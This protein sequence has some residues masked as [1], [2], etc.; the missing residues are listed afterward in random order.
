MFKIKNGTIH[1]SRGDG[2]TIK[3]KIPIVDAKDYIKYQ[4]VSNNI[5]WYNSKSKILYDSN[6]EETEV[7]LNTLS[8]VLY[9]FQVD[10]KVTFNIYEKKGYDKDPLM[11]KEVIVSEITDCV[12]IP[13]SK[14]NTTF[15]EQINKPTIFWYD[16]TLNE[17][18]T[19]VG[20]NE[21]GEKE[22]IEYPA[23]GDG[24]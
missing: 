24:E 12:D 3:L 8:M 9:E 17:K 16:I 21:D 19:I 13:L 1:C 20:Y 5:Y 10:D 11:T 2:G 14:E 4:D 22:F 23:K 6:Y 15:G 7:L 18:M